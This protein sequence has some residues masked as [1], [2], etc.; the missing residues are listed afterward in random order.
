MKNIMKNIM[1]K[2]ILKYIKG[3]ACF[4]LIFHAA[5]LSG[6]NG[7]LAL[8]DAVEMALRHN[9]EIRLL[10][11]DL[12]IAERKYK[13]SL[14]DLWMPSV[15]FQAGLT[16]MDPA[17]V[18]NAAMPE[19][20][21][22][23]T[24]LYALD[25]TTGAPVATVPFAVSVAGTNTNLNVW[26][27]NTSLKFQISKPVFTGGKLLIS[28]NMSR[29]NLDVVKRKL[30]DKKNEVILNVKNSF[31]NL[32]LTQERMKLSREI[33]NSLEERMNYT[34]ENYEAGRV[35]EY[36]FIQMKVQYMGSKPDLIEAS[37]TYKTAKLAFLNT[38][39]ISGPKSRETQYILKG[40]IYDTR[41]LTITGFLNHSG[42]ENGGLADSETADEEKIYEILMQNN[43][44]LKSLE[45]AVINAKYAK[46]LAKSAFLPN[47]SVFF[48]PGWTLKHDHLGRDEEDPSF[49]WTAGI[50]ASMPLHSL[51]IPFS[52]DFQGTKEASENYKKLITQKDHLKE[53]LILQVKTLLLKIK[54]SAMV[55]ENQKENVRLSKIGYDMAQEKY[56]NGLIN[57]TEVSDAENAYNRARLTELGA[58]Y[59]NYVSKINLLKLLNNHYEKSL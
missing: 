13:K 15:T 41:D 55:I 24:N 32:L 8:E 56:E 30:E 4:L 46:K 59:E 10:E 23:V 36:Q 58:L 43:P 28:K 51:L 22:E 54:K 52:K 50:S 11:H 18:T 31:Y 7:T 2:K 48:Q 17:S 14:A 9:P 16:V 40:S 53:T 25:I 47:V 33:E 27:L 42:I 49:N 29:Y 26:P 21:A 12:I 20:T 57:L 45:D 5:D 39:G 19:Y 3:M 37:N 6:K 35:S 34:R 38:L 44:S 1:K